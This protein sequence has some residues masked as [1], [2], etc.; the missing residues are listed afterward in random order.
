MEVVI[1]DKSTDKQGD[2]ISR[3]RIPVERIGLTR[4][5]IWRCV[6]PICL[7]IIPKISP[8]SWKGTWNTLPHSTGPNPAMFNDGMLVAI[9]ARVSSSLIFYALL[10]RHQAT[11]NGGTLY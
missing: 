10:A 1:A 11:Q 2:R 5:S 8:R 4:I 7:Y 3:S 6:V 9:S